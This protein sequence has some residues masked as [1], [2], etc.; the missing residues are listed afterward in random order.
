MHL[1]AEVLLQAAIE[2]PSCIHRLLA[3]CSRSSAKSPQTS[4]PLPLQTRWLAVGNV[5]GSGEAPQRTRT[6]FTL[7]W[8]HLHP[9]TGFSVPH[10]MV[11]IF[12]Q[13]ESPS[14]GQHASAGTCAQ[15]VWLHVGG[16]HASDQSPSQGGVV[17]LDWDLPAETQ[18]SFGKNSGQQPGSLLAQ[19]CLAVG[20]CS[21][22]ALQLGWTEAGAAVRGCP[23]DAALRDQGSDGGQQRASLP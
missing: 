17:E 20:L 23:G 5:P 8:V 22:N 11:S 3:L 18:R 10:W 14:R 19:R 9:E 4:Q 2:T 15:E 12:V 7:S 1:L 21:A 16:G 13:R 6:C